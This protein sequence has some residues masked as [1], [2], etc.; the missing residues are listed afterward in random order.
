M[1]TWN[2]LNKLK[3]DTDSQVSFAIHGGFHLPFD[4]RETD[5]DH[6]TELVKSKKIQKVTTL[7]KVAMILINLMKN[8]VSFPSMLI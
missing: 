3:N 2:Q 7:S 6:D 1:V 4:D 5:F 8:L